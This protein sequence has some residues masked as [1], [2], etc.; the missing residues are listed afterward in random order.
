MLHSQPNRLIHPPLPRPDEPSPSGNDTPSEQTRPPGDLSAGQSKFFN[1]SRSSFIP[2]FIRRAHTSPP[3]QFHGHVRL[4][5]SVHKLAL[6]RV[7]RPTPHPSNGSVIIPFM[8]ASHPRS[9]DSMV[10]YLRIHGAPNGDILC[11]PRFIVSSFHRSVAA[12]CPCPSRIWYHICPSRRDPRNPSTI[13]THPRPHPTSDYPIHSSACPSSFV[14][15]HD[16]PRSPI[17][18]L[19]IIGT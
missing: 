12:T 10:H 3:F 7:K 15:H 13:C 19:V 16:P 2:P 4:S 9:H 6:A 1:S 5:L 18:R 17:T 8:L 11:F 14:P